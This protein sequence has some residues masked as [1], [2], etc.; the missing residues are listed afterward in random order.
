M[1]MCGDPLVLAGEDHR[2]SQVRR[3]AYDQV[4]G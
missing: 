3:P 1:E 2:R 4:A